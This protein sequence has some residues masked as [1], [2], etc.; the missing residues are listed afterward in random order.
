MQG[1]TDR[2][3]ACE[4]GSRPEKA[5]I[6]RLVTGTS[7]RGLS[8]CIKQSLSGLI[9]G[10]CLAAFPLCGQTPSAKEMTTTETE[11]NFT[12]QV[13]RNLVQVRVVVRDAK[14]QPV[15]TLKKEDFLLFDSGKP[16]TITHFS[17]EHPEAARSQ[18]PPAA[19]STEPDIAEEAALKAAAPQRYL[20][21]YFDDIRMPF[22]D[23]S[24]VRKAAEAYLTSSLTPGDRVGIFTSSGQGNQ[25]FTADRDAM[26]A[27]LRR[28]QPRLMNP[29]EQ[30]ACP[31]IFDY[32]AY[33]MVMT[34]DMFAKNIA[35]QE[36]LYCRF[37]GD[38]R[39]LDQAAADAQT[40]AVRE[41][42]KYQNAS[43]ASLR[44]LNEVIRRMSVVP[45]QRSLVLI[46]TGFLT[47]GLENRLDE[48]VDKALREKVIVSTLD[49]QG[50]DATPA[51]GGVDE[52]RI[53]VPGRSDLNGRKLEYRIEASSRSKDVLSTMAEGTGGVFFHNSNDLQEGFR[54]VSGL[55]S[56][57]YSLAFSPDKLKF[58]GHFHK[59]T[60][61]L[62]N[63]N[64]L[65]VEARQGYFAPKQSTAPEDRAKEEIA[66]A[67]FSQDD[68]SQIPIEV[69]T[70]FFK[71]SRE[72][73]TL[74]VVARV[75]LRFL[76]FRKAEGRNLN[77]LTV[78]TALFDRNGNFIK[79][80]ERRVN[81]QLLDSS[82]EKLTQSG[83]TMR[84]SFDVTPG[85]YMIREVVRDSEGSKISGLTRTIE[86]PY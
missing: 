82:L 4:V 32:Q 50:L 44:G 76:E 33:L 60:V 45:G 66:S 30:N 38:T 26:E 24:L 86:I 31:Q 35:T 14:G 54:R 77:N 29:E 34:S 74:S 23:I 53:F 18:T 80:K 67:I 43:D 65:T 27:A 21:L 15:G 83:I 11:P 57:Y 9:I 72:E 39:F 78:V 55:P 41:F 69:Q 85:T 56:V 48:S 47:A 36:D 68:L 7:L 81:F 61:K 28:L 22:A 12:L 75:D 13:E 17:V 20:A 84:T 37:Q 64:S 8:Y 19:K 5:A 51:S 10:L 2:R 46:S 52:Q 73:A 58:D 63:R 70:Q 16:Q 40:E 3:I 1:R 42:E 62:V 6:V 71:G 59:L 49:S 79:G 25:D